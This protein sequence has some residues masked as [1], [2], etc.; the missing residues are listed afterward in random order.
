MAKV[1]K[2]LKWCSDDLKKQRGRDLQLI[3]RTRGRDAIMNFV[4]IA[5]EADDC[6]RT[7]EENTGLEKAYKLLKSR[8]PRLMVNVTATPVPLFREFKEKK[9]SHEVLSIKPDPKEY[10]GLDKLDTFRDSGG[11]HIYL[12]D[13]DLKIGNGHLVDG[14]RIPSTCKASMKFY[15]DALSDH[16]AKGILLC[17]ISNHL[18]Y[19]DDNILQ[20][21]ELSECFIPLQISLCWKLLL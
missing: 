15:Q 7:K 4:L 10:L 13:D 6:Y 3:K 2:L 20:K 11:E 21:A 9:V 17:D 1:S 19:C 5:D 12:K 14:I 8:G 16:N 18:V